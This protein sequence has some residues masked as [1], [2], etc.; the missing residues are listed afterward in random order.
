MDS[1]AEDEK[2]VYVEKYKQPD[3]VG[4]LNYLY[5]NGWSATS[6][7]IEWEENKTSI[8]F[9]YPYAEN[10]VNER[11]EA[12]YCIYVGSGNIDNIN[13]LAKY[14]SAIWLTPGKSVTAGNSW[15][16]NGEDF[17]YL[18]GLTEGSKYQINLEWN[19]TNH[20]VKVSLNEIEAGQ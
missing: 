11:N 3:H 6:K 19:E 20:T 10:W 1:P 17:I 12:Q 5:S 15:D 14:G 7:Y 13:Y 8:T 16:N 18:N 2:Y 9:D 4:L